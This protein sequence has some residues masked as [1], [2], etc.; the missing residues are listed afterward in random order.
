MSTTRDYTLGK[1]KMLFKKDGED[2]YRDLGNA[3]ALTLNVT[4]DKLEHFSS[5][6]GVS[7]KDLEVI[8]QLTVGGS[9]TLD[10]ANGDNLSMF[11]M[12]TGAVADDQ[13]AD[14]AVSFD[15][16]NAG[17]DVTVKALGS[18]IPLYLA[19]G[20]RAINLSN[21][22][23]TDDETGPNT[24]IAGIEGVGHYQ[25]DLTA[26]LLWINA[27]QTTPSD[28]GGGN[29][30]VDDILL[31]AGDHAVQARSASDGG[32]L[33]TLKGNVLFVGAPPQGRILDVTGYCSL[34]PNGDWSLIGDDWMQYTF[35]IEFLEVVGVS[36][37]VQVIDR[38]KVG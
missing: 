26:G 16:G 6:E 25:V 21:L 12:S 36:G 28:P 8:T 32:T 19:T 14:T 22:T 29:I 34:T 20:E 35:D 13:A 10:E 18:W 30:A 1:G 9:F 4:I 2:Y 27:D 15:D 5:R 11:I 23:V 38:G 17:A 7:K 3:P 33:T 31:V 37:V 24:Y